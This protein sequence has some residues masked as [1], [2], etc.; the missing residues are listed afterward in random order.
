[1]K[2]QCRVSRGKNQGKILTPHKFKNGQYV[3]SK[4]RDK[5]DWENSVFL[6]DLEDIK[7]LKLSEGSD[8]K[9]WGSGN[10]IQ[11][12]LANDLVDELWLDTYPITLGQGKKLFEDGA[13]PAAFTLVEAT[14]TP[15][16][17][18]MANYKRAGDVT[19]GTVGD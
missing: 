15:A 2:L 7:N 9:V 18:I 6:T 8:I 17:V 3:V 5:S 13:I 4:T 16:G 10:L 11:T 19:T 1:M 14:V 12:L